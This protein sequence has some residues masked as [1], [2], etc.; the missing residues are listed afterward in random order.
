M[1]AAASPP[2]M[3]LNIKLKLHDCDDYDSIKMS[4]SFH[5]ID[6]Y[7][8]SVFKLISPYF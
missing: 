6:D 5:F 3:N 8:Y 7:M 1:S 2:H 4:T